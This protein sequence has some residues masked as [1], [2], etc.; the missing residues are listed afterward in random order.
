MRVS[1]T[2]SEYRFSFSMPSMFWESSSS[3][4][5]VTVGGFFKIFQSFF[6]SLF[7]LF[8]F[9]R[10]LQ[11]VK[12]KNKLFKK[13]Q[14]DFFWEFWCADQI[15]WSNRLCFAIHQNWIESGTLETSTHLRQFRFFCSQIRI[16]FFLWSKLANWK[17]SFWFPFIFAV[18]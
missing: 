6:T 10:W 1:E 15:S 11:T 17:T 7:I 4:Y 13:H 14:F 9:W 3:T 18:I 2:Y 5:Y 12:N 16:D 8:C